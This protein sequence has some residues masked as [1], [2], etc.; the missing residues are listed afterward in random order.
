[1]KKTCIFSLILFAFCILQ[2]Q[3]NIE[4]RFD[5]TGIYSNETGLLKS[6]KPEGPELL[7]HYD[8]LGEG[9][10]SVAIANNKIYVTGLVDGEGH[11]FVFD[12]YGKI[13]KKISY[14]TEWDKSYNGSRGTV[15][16]ND[17]KL[18]IF[19]GTGNL[20]CMDKNSYEIVWKKNIEDF[21]GS[22][23]RW[24]VCESPL[25][26]DEK[27]ILSV[28]GKEHN[29]VALNKKDGSKIWSSPGK[30]DPSSYCSPLY[31]TNQEVPLIITTMAKNIVGI[32]AT[33]GKL[34]WSHKYENDRQIHPNTPV[35]DGKD[36]VLI[37][38]GYDLG[39]VMLRL[40]NGGRSIEKVWENHDIKSKHGGIVKIGDYAYIGGDSR[41]SKFWHCVEWNS[42]KVMYKDNTITEGVV[43]ADGDGMLYLYS[44]RGEMALVKPT[45]EKFDLVSKFMITMGTEQHW[46]HPVLHKGIMYVRHGNTLMAY[47]VK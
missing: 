21:G 33:T 5:R 25:I 34:L 28:G 45:P 13:L 19:T 14:G 2:A 44:E 38:H 41:S 26:I 15:T 43:I 47:K 17:G 11:L 8:G 18:Y 9:H 7:W 29:I 10:S 22:N 40:I 36:M 37:T 30:G 27:V 46:A 16:V 42:G 6:W 20:I 31:I 32:E 24:G 39:S 23:I 12:M 35:Y 1:M 3:D 4:W